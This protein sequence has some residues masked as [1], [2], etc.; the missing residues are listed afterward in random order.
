MN[1]FSGLLFTGWLIRKAYKVQLSS[2]KLQFKLVEAVQNA[3]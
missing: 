3:D 2:D 1:M